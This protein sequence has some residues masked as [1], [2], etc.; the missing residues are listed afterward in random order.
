M[1]HKLLFIRESL[2]LTQGELIEEFGLA[3]VIKQ[4][5][6]SAWEKGIREPDLQSLLKYARK[7]NICLEILVDDSFDLPKYIPAS[8][9]DHRH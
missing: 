4:Q 1:A 2:E 8:T 7:A 6:I 5:H 3:R 9:C